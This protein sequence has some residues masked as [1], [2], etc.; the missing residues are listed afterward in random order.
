MAVLILTPQ[1][2]TSLPQN[3]VYDKVVAA[4]VDLNRFLYLK[5]EG[6]FMDGYGIGSYPDGFYPQQNPTGFKPTTKALVAKTGFH[7]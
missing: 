1:T 5:V 3:H 4:R 7:F 2:D 6:R